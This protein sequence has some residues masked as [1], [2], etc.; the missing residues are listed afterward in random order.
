MIEARPT[1]Q[2]PTPVATP[3]LRCTRCHAMPMPGGAMNGPGELRCPK[4]DA[5]FPVRSGRFPDFLDD[6]QRAKLEREIDYWKEHFGGQ[7]YQDEA[8]RSYVMWAEYL[9][10]RPEDRVLEIGCGSGAL[11]R[12]LPAK[13]RYGVEPAASLLDTSREFQGIIAA[14]ENLPFADE[15]FDLVFFKHALHHVTD[16]RRAFDEAVRVTRKGGRVA[17]IEPNAV[18]P[19]RRLVARPDGFFRRNRILSRL[20]SPVET[21]QSADELLEWGRESGL[22][23]RRLEYHESLYDRLTLRQALQKIY[24]MA[25][26]GW[27]AARLRFPNYCAVF[28]K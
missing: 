12:R 15:A 21:F 25:T 17:F 5:H 26:A 27:L 7:D 2:P 19:H 23:L 28:D 8:D 6:I 4:C 20:L 22:R 16:K 11:L 10:V 1:G 9:E 24:R 18:H 3:A 14:A 13:V